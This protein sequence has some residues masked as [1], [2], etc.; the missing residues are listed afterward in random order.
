MRRIHLLLEHDIT[1]LVPRP[2]ADAPGQ[3]APTSEIPQGF[4]GELL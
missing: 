1:T 3:R 4:K 2:G